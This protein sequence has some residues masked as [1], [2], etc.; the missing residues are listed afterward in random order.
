MYATRLSYAPVYLIHDEVKFAL[1]AQSIADSG[2]DLNG[3][4]FPV[5]FSEPEFP[6]GRDPLVIYATAAVLKVLPLSESAVRLPAAIVSVVT[7]LLIALLARRLFE[8]D[9]LALAAGAMYALSPGAFLHGRMGLSVLYPI[10]F[11]MLWALGLERYQR[12]RRPAALV[13]AGAAL[14]M[15][16]Y[17]YLAGMV[18]MPVY[19]ALTG[20]WL[21]APPVPGSR[22]P[23]SRFPAPGP[24][25]WAGSSWASR[26]RS[27]PWPPGRSRIRSG[28][29]S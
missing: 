20:V 1:Q 16:G 29:A 3:R 11:V 28:L 2:R 17:G 14:V 21:L 18:M 6:A 7:V 23:S 8:S 15:G 13:L 9:A 24:S 25:P 10:P 22:L 5:Y 19:V 12:H 4:L 27:S 26:S